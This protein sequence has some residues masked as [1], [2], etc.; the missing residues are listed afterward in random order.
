MISSL[1]P[2]SNMSATD[3]DSFPSTPGNT[4]NPTIRDQ[5]NQQVKQTASKEI[6]SFTIEAKNYSYSLP[7]IRIKRQSM[8]SITLINKEGT[9]DFVIDE[10]HMK[11][12]QLNTGEKDTI[13]LIADNAG[14]YE[15]YCSVENH[16]AL[17][18]KGKLIIE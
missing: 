7:E 3:A 12:K 2:T 6:R 18:M 5:I 10:L 11:S 13:A 16:R 9:H 8:V 1:I 14:I 15:Y 4:L 17:G